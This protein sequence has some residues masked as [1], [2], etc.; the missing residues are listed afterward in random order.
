MLFWLSYM[1]QAFFVR[2]GH[3]EG[4]TS[5]AAKIHEQYQDDFCTGY[6][7]RCDT[8]AHA[9]C[10]DSGYYVKYDHREIQIL[11]HGDQKSCSHGQQHMGGKYS[12]SFGNRFILQTALENIDTIR[13]G[14][15]RT[16]VK[17]Q[18]CDSGHFGSAR[19]GTRTATDKHQYD[20]KELAA[21]TE[22]G[23][24]RSVKTCGS[25]CDCTK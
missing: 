15:H 1:C 4:K 13:A 19:C 8:G 17:N 12:G 23:N 3:C 18:N 24:I 25:W 10:A 5:Y 20:G 2:K 11:L 22:T 16:Q 21:L 6:K 7:I 14:Q 9:D